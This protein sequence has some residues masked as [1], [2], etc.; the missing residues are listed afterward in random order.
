MSIPATWTGA[1]RDAL[2]TA[3][4]VPTADSVQPLTGGLSGAPVFRIEVAGRPYLL[5]LDPPVEGIADPRRWHRC[6]QIAADLE[7]APKVHFTGP[8]GVSIIDFVTPD[9]VGACWRGDR[10]RLLADIGALLR[11][12]HEGSAF[13]PLVD[14][15]DGLE[16]LARPLK[17]W[18]EFTPALAAFRTLA[19]AYRRLESQLVASHND[20]NPTNLIHDGQRLWLI[21][22]AA[23]FQADRYID[24]AAVAGFFARDEASGDQLLTAYFGRPPTPAE[25]GRFR[26]ARL[27]NHFFYGV[28]MTGAEPPTERRDLEALHLALRQGEAVFASPGGRAEYARARLDALIAAVE[29]P[30]FEEDCRLAA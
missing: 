2:D 15:L 26:L 19:K 13:P 5:R 4:G 21:D 22:W 29:A 9:P 27:I 3:F 1:V 17:G 20:V 10:Q 30:A 24:L 11:R 25:Q 28:V 7:V 12:L 8:S 6:L 16:Q 18:P 23:A 14:Y